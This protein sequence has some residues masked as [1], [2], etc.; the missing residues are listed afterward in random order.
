VNAG[1]YLLEPAVVRSIPN[2]R[3]FDMTELIQRL[4]DEGRA[5][6][7]FPIVGY[8]LDIGKYGDYLQA[9]EDMKSG[10]FPA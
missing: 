5:V 4:L 7:T 1:I 6:A 9:Q 2:G 10:R 8:W 3:R